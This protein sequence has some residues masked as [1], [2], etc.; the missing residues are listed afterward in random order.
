MT[1]AIKMLKCKFK[2]GECERGGGSSF[3]QCAHR[4][5]ILLLTRS[6]LRLSGG[7]GGSAAVVMMIC[8][9]EDITLLSG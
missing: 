8:V 5:P 3:P 2:H 1:R 7:R 4:K 6:E 9:Y